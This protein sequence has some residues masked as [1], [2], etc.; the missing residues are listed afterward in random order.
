M[1]NQLRV[2]VRLLNKVLVRVNMARAPDKT[3]FGII[4]KW[5]DFFGYHS[6]KLNRIY[7]RAASEEVVRRYDRTSW[8]WTDFH[9]GNKAG[10]DTKF[11]MRSANRPGR[12][13]EKMALAQGEA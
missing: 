11:D 13:I 9:P 6:D 7:E 4:G 1:K 10:V 2:G 3:L 8:N 12:T 5:S